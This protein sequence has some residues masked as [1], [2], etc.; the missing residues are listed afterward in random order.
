LL[1]STDIRLFPCQRESSARAFAQN[2]VKYCAGVGK[3]GKERKNVERRFSDRSSIDDD[4]INAGKHL[5]ILERNGFLLKSVC[6]MKAQYIPL[7][8]TTQREIIYNH[9]QN[10]LQPFQSRGL[11]T[12]FYHEMTHL[13]SDFAGRLGFIWLPRGRDVHY[14]SIFLHK[15][16]LLRRC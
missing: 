4:G 6:L 1:F 10:V 9:E 11:R 5:T 2:L 12:T 3:G 7:K 13:R 8:G 15:C 14:K 16:P